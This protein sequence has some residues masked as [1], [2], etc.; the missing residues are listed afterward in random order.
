MSN[1]EGSAPRSDCSERSG[2]RGGGSTPPVAAMPASVQEAAEDHRGPW[3]EVVAVVVEEQRRPRRHSFARRLEH[4]P[5]T[6]RA[7]PPSTS[8]PKRSAD[9]SERM[10]HVSRCDRGSGR[11]RP[12]VV[13]AATGGDDVRRARPRRVD[14]QRTRARSARG[15]RSVSARSSSSSQER[16]RNSTSGTSGSRSLA[17]ALELGLR[18]GRLL[19]ARVVLEEDPAQLPESSSGSSERAELGERLGLLSRLVPRHRGVRLDVERELR[20]RCAGPSGPSRPDRGGGSRASRPRPCRTA[21]R[22]SRAEPLD[23]ETPS[24][25]PSLRSSPSS[26]KLHVPRR[27]VAGIGGSVGAGCAAPTRSVRLLLLPRPP[28]SGRAKPFTVGLTHGIGAMSGRRLGATCDCGTRGRHCAAR[29]RT[30]R[31]SP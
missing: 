20:R 23:V 2:A 18:L 17:H 3:R 13:A 14:G 16:C 30:C 28:C 26:A 12:H 1:G 22:S 15:T 10:F 29:G 5:P 6:R 31:S 4:R 7:P 21:R 27:T 24:R 9:F 25:V 8:S 19:N 11:M